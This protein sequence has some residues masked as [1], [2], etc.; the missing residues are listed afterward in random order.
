MHRPDIDIITLGCS[1]NLVDTERLMRQLELLGYDCRHNSPN[2]KAGI[3][4]INTCA[5][6]GDAKEESIN[7]I[8]QF[9]QRK[10]T[11]SLKELYVMGCLSQRYLSDLQKE[12][13]EVDKFY[14]KF[15]FLN[16]LK[17]L[18][19]QPVS[20]SFQRT[21]TTPQH[22]AYL[23]IAEGCTRH[24]SYCAIPIITGHY[25][26]RTIED[27]LNE[28]RWLADKG[29]KELQ[30]I[31]QD[32]TYY[33]QD[34]YHKP[35]IAQLINAIA[36]VKG[37][38]W[39]RLHYAYPAHFP[40]ELLQVIRERPNVCKYLDIALQ[41]C[42]DSMLFA[43]RRNISAVEQIALIKTIREEVPG[44]HLRTTLMVGHPRETEGDFEALKQFVRD[45]RFERMGAFA[46]SHEENTYSALHYQDEISE[47]TK[48]RRLDEL[49]NIQQEIAEEINA[50]KVGQLFKVII[51][52]E[53]DDYYI[54]RTQY[55]SPEVDQEVLIRKQGREQQFDN[56]LSI[57][58]FYTAKI[59]DSQSFDL[60]AEIIR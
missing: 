51:D 22:Y 55:D 57:G 56:K 27:I 58:N 23:K 24:F 17:D 15:D 2:P 40:L 8:L 34:L 9:A 36:D 4:V 46:Y 11:G 21:I 14:G 26:S 59:I 5:F 16:L 52:S 35:Q 28:V 45:M 44:I 13:P 33:G 6:I 18:N 12:I 19:R 10:Q 37:I 3:A 48:Q 43:M 42:T 25:K 54:A 30:V 53:E 31:A 32:L 1:K 7:T 49:M 38:E 29:V 20:P 60:Y 41:H 50:Q 47:E 39:I